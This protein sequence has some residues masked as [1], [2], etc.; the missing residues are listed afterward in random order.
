MDFI[1]R[2][3]AFERFPAMQLSAL[4]RRCDK[5]ATACRWQVVIVCS[6]GRSERERPVDTSARRL[7]L[8]L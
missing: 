5:L 2:E 3:L 6:D 4:A 1:M 7:D 8:A